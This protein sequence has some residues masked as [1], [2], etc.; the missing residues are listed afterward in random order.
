MDSGDVVVVGSEKY[1]WEIGRTCSITSKWWKPIQHRKLLSKSWILT[2]IIHVIAHGLSVP[3]LWRFK[4]TK[5]TFPLY[6][7][8]PMQHPL[9]RAIT[10]IPAKNKT[11]PAMQIKRTQKYKKEETWS[12]N[13]NIHLEGCNQ[14]GIGF[15]DEL[16][17]SV[18]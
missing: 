12:K 6:S 1:S 2:W 4:P 14:R 17:D 15:P 8:H 13:D 18:Y 11:H 9:L 3:R 10:D 16:C 5:S 7:P